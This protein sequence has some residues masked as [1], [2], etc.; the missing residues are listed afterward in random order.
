MEFAVSVDEPAKV[1]RAEIR[2]P[3][4]A[5]GDTRPQ[6][7]T[8]WRANFYRH[9]RRHKAGLAFSPTLNPSFHTP[10]RFGWLEF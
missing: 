3:L 6:A 1:W 2:I 8:R 5:I 10:D 9:D 4:T 7:G